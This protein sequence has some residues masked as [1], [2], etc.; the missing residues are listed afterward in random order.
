MLPHPRDR[1]RRA[2]VTLSIHAM[3]V[4]REDYV[5]IGHEVLQRIPFFVEIYRR[6]YTFE[7][8]EFGIAHD[9]I[10]ILQPWF[11]SVHDEFAAQHPQVRVFLI[12]M[13]DIPIGEVFGVRWRV[14]SI[15]R[16]VYPD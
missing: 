13:R 1:V 3:R 6:R 15:A 7:T 9:E 10:R 8:R 12:S 11:P 14:K 2:L 4:Q 16:S 5:Q